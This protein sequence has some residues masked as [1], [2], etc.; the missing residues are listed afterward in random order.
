MMDGAMDQSG[1]VSFLGR[2]AKELTVMSFAIKLKLL[3]VGYLRPTT[4]L[5]VNKFNVSCRFTVV[6]Y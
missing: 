6:N 2:L 4:W 3:V 1:A 5:T